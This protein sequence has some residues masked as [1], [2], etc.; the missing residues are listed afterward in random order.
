MLEGHAL[1]AHTYELNGLTTIRVYQ[2]AIIKPV[3]LFK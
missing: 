2:V 1:I 3:R